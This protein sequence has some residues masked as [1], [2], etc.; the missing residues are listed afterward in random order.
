MN[1][2]H[3]SAVALEYVGLHDGASRRGLCPVCKGGSSGELSFAVTREGRALLYVCHRASCDTSG[4]LTANDH[5]TGSVHR[6][7]ERRTEQHR[8]PYSLPLHPLGDGWKEYLFNKYY[9]DG[10]FDYFDGLR[11]TED[12]RLA[13]PVYDDRGAREDLTLR[14][15]RYNIPD[16]PKGDV[17]VSDRKAWTGASWYIRAARSAKDYAVPGALVL[18]EDQLS[19][20]RLSPHVHAMSLL[21]VGMN[22]TK[23]NQIADFILR[24]GQHYDPIDT[25]VLAFD[26][27]A[28]KSA[29]KVWREYKH[30]LPLK[31][32]RLHKDFKNMTPQELIDKIQE[33]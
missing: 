21:G 20:I 24:C 11:V 2:Q 10:T 22:I 16:V 26:A 13:L 27:D 17:Y 12:R 9:L 28:T 3:K 5:S 23:V 30:W 19:A 1:K 18:V 29:I 7:S 4:V 32:M 6:P 15:C 14:N 8:P 31:V 25:V 33:V